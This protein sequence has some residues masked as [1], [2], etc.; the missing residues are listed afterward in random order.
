MPWFLNSSLDYQYCTV[1][2]NVHQQDIIL[3]KNLSSDSPI[4]NSR[5]HLKHSALRNQTAQVQAFATV[6]DVAKISPVVVIPYSE[7]Y[8]YLQQVGNF[9]FFHLRRTS[10]FLSCSTLICVRQ[11]R[12]S[13]LF[14]GS[15]SF[16]ALCWF[17]GTSSRHFYSPFLCSKD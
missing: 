5:L 1:A 7:N 17:S 11:L 2:G 16:S 8:V 15:L 10:D 3:A 4:V 12:T 13:L 14:V 6:L 9:P